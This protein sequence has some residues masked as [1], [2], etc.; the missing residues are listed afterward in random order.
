LGD[1]G[2]I[3]IFGHGVVVEADQGNVGRYPKAHAPQCPQGAEGHLIGFGEDGR[4]QPAA[5]E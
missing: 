3:E 2:E 4:G 5:A 1:C